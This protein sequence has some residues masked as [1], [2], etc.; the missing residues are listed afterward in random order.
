MH[1]KVF[2]RE[3]STYVLQIFKE[4]APELTVEKLNAE[5]VYLCRAYSAMPTL[6]PRQCLR[7]P[8]VGASL[9]ESVLVKDYVP[10]R[11]ELALTTVD[12]AELDATTRQ[13]IAQFLSITRNL[14]ADTSADQPS[15]VPDF[16][17]PDCANL[18]IDIRTG[19]LKLIDTNRLI[20]TRKPARLYAEGQVL[21]V[22][23]DRNFIHGLLFRRMLFLE[24]KFLDRSRDDLMR[25]PAY[26]RYLS[27]A[28]FET[29][30]AASEAAGE[31]L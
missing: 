1:S 23:E 9:Q 22:T 3:N 19:D 31:S 18:V 25:D 30:F 8:Y 27:R 21:D 12:P 13:Q 7:R 17:D 15:M 28:G 6:I 29:L 4:D 24:M 5:Y 26:A 11:T 16:I 14:L 20:S 2:R 10:H